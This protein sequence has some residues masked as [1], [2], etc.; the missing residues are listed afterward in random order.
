MNDSVR[1]QNLTIFSCSSFS[2]MLVRMKLK[3]DGLFPL[4]CLVQTVTSVP[5][6]LTIHVICLI[7]PR[8]CPQ[9]QVQ[10]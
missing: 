3:L 1:V 4:F 6:Q 10:S 5:W 9:D 2:Q 7:L 8:K